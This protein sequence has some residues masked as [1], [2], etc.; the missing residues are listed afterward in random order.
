MKLISKKEVQALRTKSI[1]K[2]NLEKDK[3]EKALSENI[4][5]FNEWKDTRKREELKI[6]IDFKARMDKYNKQVDDIISEIAILSKQK[7]KAMIP[8]EKLLKEA[9]QVMKENLEQR[10]LIENEAKRLLG[11]SD[12]NKETQEKI[13]KKEKLVNK[14]E[15]LIKLAENSLKL[16]QESTKIASGRLNKEIKAFE[17]YKDTENAKI[18]DKLDEIRIKNDEINAQ[19][20]AIKEQKLQNYKDAQKN[21]SDRQA[22]NTAWEELKK[23]KEKYDR[24]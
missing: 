20:K 7:E 10:E 24:R 18:Q 15:I 22:V 3:V 16:E 17:A 14:R 5:A 13:D 6:E 23:L 1:D 11:V 19:N 2:A 4:R 21:I 8:V 12:Q 9:E